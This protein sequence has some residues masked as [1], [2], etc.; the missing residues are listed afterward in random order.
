MH[1]IG[2]A[3]GFAIRNGGR[4]GNI[5]TLFVANAPGDGYNLLVANNS[6]VI[7]AFAYKSPGYDME[8]DFAP[9]TLLGTAPVL[10]VIHKDVPA[11]N[12]KEFV[13]YARKNPGKLNMSTAGGGTPGH[14][15]NLLFNK[16]AGLKM[17]HIPYKGSG[18]ATLAL[19]QH[20]VDV[21]FATPAAVE[22]HVKSGAF[23]AIGVTSKARFNAFSTVPTVMEAGVPELA[24][25]NMDIWWGVLAPAKTDPAVLDKLHTHLAAAVNDPKNRE[26]WLA[27]G[28]VP[29]VL[30][31][32]EFTTMI[33]NDMRRWEQVIKENN[34]T[35]E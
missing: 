33:R 28:M 18:P 27:Q 10:I 21:F 7:N 19:L 9:L 2:K 16:Q 25:Y 20:E 23:K 26:R 29:T 32:A 4:N 12:L 13:E 8:E 35:A 34:I 24:Q 31:R 30:S 6:Q 3:R 1:P 11:N 17:T 15:A 5:G 22:P 14:L